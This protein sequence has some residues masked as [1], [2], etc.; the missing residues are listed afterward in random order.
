[1][2]VAFRPIIVVQCAKLN[3]CGAEECKMTSGGCLLSSRVQTLENPHFP[4]D[5]ATATAAR[6][7]SNQATWSRLHAG[8]RPTNA[9]FTA[10]EIF[11]QK[12]S[13][14]FLE[15]F[16]CPLL[17]LCWGWGQL[18]AQHAIITGSCLVKDRHFIQ[19]KVPNIELRNSN[20][21]WNF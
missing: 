13:G 14:C 3:G 15:W 1:M 5:D 6:T 16:H 19:P 11:S 8:H 7:S 9:F 10:G 17:L 2:L 20:Q 18:R 4:R 12:S 21:A